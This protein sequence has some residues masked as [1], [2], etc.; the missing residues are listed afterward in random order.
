M[1]RLILLFSLFLVAHPAFAGDDEDV[2]VPLEL[3]L[4]AHATGNGDHIREGFWSD[5]KLTAWRDG[6]FVVI[7]RDEYAARFS[8]KPAADEAQRKRRIV[9]VDRSGDAA[10][11]KIELDYTTVTF[12]DYMTLHK[13]DGQWKIVH[14]AFQ[15]TQKPKQ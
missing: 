1:R 3:Y 6:K 13:I 4:K 8:G 12:I 2:R 9:S 10:I 11:A 5:A 7:P 15:A 14:K